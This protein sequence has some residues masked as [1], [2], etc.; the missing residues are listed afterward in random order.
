MC[1]ACFG[2]SFGRDGKGLRNWGCCTATALSSDPAE[3]MRTF[4]LLR[5]SKRKVG[6]ADSANLE[7]L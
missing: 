1:P 3:V 5:P 4:T 7:N 2:E 6:P